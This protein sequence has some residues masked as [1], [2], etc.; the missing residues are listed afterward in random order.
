MSK[1]CGF[2]CLR[3]VG[4]SPKRMRQRDCGAVGGGRRTGDGGY[5]MQNV[6]ALVSTL[7][8][9]IKSKGTID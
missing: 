3:F 2:C 4:D 1:M 7:P 8:S 9:V 5:H 6:F